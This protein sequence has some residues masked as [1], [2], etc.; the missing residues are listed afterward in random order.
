MSDSAGLLCANCDI[1]DLGQCNLDKAIEEFESVSWN[2]VL[3][4]FEELDNANKKPCW[5]DLTFR[6]G[7]YHIAI[8]SGDNLT[9][10]N[11]EVCMPRVKKILCIFGGTKFYELK[12][13]DQSVVKQYI[14]VFYTYSYSQQNEYF[15]NQA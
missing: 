6:I 3:S 8:S 7:N 5:P 9:K 4:E 10:Y 2:K 11:V 1:I 14:K 12:N 15:L 13:L